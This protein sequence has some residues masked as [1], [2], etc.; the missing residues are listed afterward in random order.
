MPDK[1]P[2]PP[3][4]PQNWYWT[5]PYVAVVVFALSMLALVWV[6][7]AREAASAHASIARDVQWAEQTMRIHMQGTEEFLGQLARDLAADALDADGFQLRANQQIAANGE[8]VNIVWIGADGVTRWSAPFD[9]T[10]WLAGDVLGAAQLEPFRRAEQRRRIAYG[11]PYRGARGESVIEVYMP[12]MR[13]REFRGAV[14]AAY[15]VERFVRYLIPRWFDE[16]YRLA[17]LDAQG[18]VLAL[19]SRLRSLDESVAFRVPLD[20][21]GNGIVLEATA[22]RTGGQWAKVL[23]AALI[24][25]LSMIVLWS[26]WT[27]RAHVVRRVQV[28]KERDRLFNLSLDMLCVVDLDGTFRRANPAFERILGLSASSLVGTRLLDIVHPDDVGATLQQLRTL[29]GGTP[30]TF[31]NRCREREGGYR[32]LV[33]NIN[34]VP[35]EKLLYAVAHDIS[36]RK[37]TEEALRAESA[38]R[39]AMEDS[40]LTGLRAIDLEGRI[41]YVNSAFCRIVGFDEAELVGAAPPFP[42]WPREEFAVCRDKLELTLAGQAP[43]SGFEL[44]IQRKS[45]ERIDARFYIS[46]LIDRSGR[47]AGW[48]ASVT[49]ITE[50][51]RVRAALEAAHSRFEAVIDGLEAA[52]FVADARTDEILFA[53][54]AFK[55]IHGFDVVGRTLRGMAVP[56]PERGDYRVDPR[57]LSAAALPREL[58]DGELQ[59]PLSGRWYHVREHATR[60][61]DGRTVRMGIATDVTDRKQMAEISRQQEER[62][63]RTSRLITM[64]E[65]ASTLAHELNQPLAAI[66]N[67]CAGCV[68]RIESGRS[69]QEELL[70][71]MRKASAQAER[72]GKIIR[73][74]REFVKKSEPRRH[75]V[76][77]TDILDDTLG[78]ADIDARRVG[79]RIVAEIADGLAPVFADRIMIEQVL[80]NLIRNGFDA[81]ADT[82]PEQRVLTVR[83]RG[84]GDAAIEVAVIDRGHG[85]SEEGRQQLFTPF[86]TTKT[87]G[88]GMGLNICRSI[89]EFHNG[90]LLVDANPEGGTIFSFTLPTE[91]ASERI[92]RSA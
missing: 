7:Q 9:T 13:G 21:P 51:K 17:L 92:A 4:A 24:V 8:L 29:A 3:R 90:R 36:G 55:T 60:W 89:V 54:R 68:T 1:P 74:I 91:T 32:W 61:V 25:G 80:L 6:L 16:K 18:G 38:F 12:V 65:M 45:G 62:L 39:K 57:G 44:P 87:E 11:E 30:V 66:A 49:D 27:L 75:A 81:M 10:D 67:Y 41:I 50:P 86:Y 43:A 52:V 34:P 78:F 58:F 48:M 15:S 5:A 35:E 84:C 88:M 85:I 83:V 19:N 70:T 28:E 37:E 72:A 22:F 79:I 40:M 77:V 69:S 42:Y 82:L 64:G 33:W 53:N 26:L 71:V 23:P 59:H 14:A 76:Q 56:Q 73:R 63:Q 47:Q 46:P 31:E 2:P 20:P